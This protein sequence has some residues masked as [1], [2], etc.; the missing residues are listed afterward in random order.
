[1]IQKRR[2]I[3]SALSL[4]AAGVLLLA[5]SGTARAQVRVGS[6]ITA[7]PGD[8]IAK[9]FPDVAFDD[10]N[11][12]YLVITGLSVVEARYV[13]PNGTPLGTAAKISTTTAGA[14]R[15][16]CAPAINRCL[17]VWLQEPRSVVG[18]LVR[19]NA[20]AVQALT[21]PFAINGALAPLMTNSAPGVVYSSVSNEFLVAWGEY[22]PGPNIR[23]KRV[24]GSGALVGAVIPI[25]VS[26]LWEGF[27]TLAYNS[28]ENEYNVGYYFETSSGASSVGTQLVKP[29]TGAL[30][31]GRSTLYSGGFNQYPEL[32]YNSTTNQYLAIS[33]GYSGASWML[34]GRLADSNSQP[35]GASTLALAAKGGGDGIGLGYNQV[36]NTYLADYQS[37]TNAET[38]GVEVSAAGGPGT[39][40]QLSVTGTTLSV[41]PRAKA[42]TGDDRWLMVTSNAF[43]NVVAQVVGHGL[44]PAPTGGGTGTGGTSTCKTI[45]PG[46]NF[47]CVNGNWLPGTSTGGT[48]GGCTTPSPGTGFTCVNG[49]WLPPSTGGGGTTSTCKTAKPAANWVCVSGNWLPPW[50]APASSSCT[51]P[52][53]ASNFVCVNGNWL[54]GDTSGG[55]SSGTCT[56]I[57][58]GP[59]WICKNGNWLPPWY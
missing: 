45:K 37:Q 39:Q 15:V 30:I 40:T 42:E 13:A 22:S 26:T 34:R 48:T 28:I 36:S 49:N 24:D 3:L 58:P 5:V 2:T 23:G 59:N 31:G 16:A 29:G 9:R 11:N 52:K 38:W 55:T 47:V 4:A 27:P 14:S 50:M 1:M 25:A 19:Y 44:T 57:K 46:P 35:L 10:A 6:T 54:P 12:A 53:P 21:S 20:G 41:Q 56:T 7:I 17:I 32:A 8:G 18:R 43:K 51:T 33:W